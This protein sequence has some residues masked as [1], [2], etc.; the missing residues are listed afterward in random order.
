MYK[1]KHK[2]KSAVLKISQAREGHDAELR[3]FKI[4]SEI[5]EHLREYVPKLEATPDPPEGATSAIVVSPY[6]P[7]IEAKDHN[8]ASQMG[9][10]RRIKHY[11]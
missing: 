10:M 7:K 11:I 1:V 6:C 5:P 2:G 3:A 4:L 9:R 8:G